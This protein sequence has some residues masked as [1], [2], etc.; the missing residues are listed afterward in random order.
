MPPKK[1]SEVDYKIACHHTLS[2]D[3]TVLNNDEPAPPEFIAWHEAKTSL[4]A[5][6]GAATWKLSEVNLFFLSGG[7]IAP[8]K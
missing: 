5:P 3:G 8:A 2:A 4:R 7:A 1:A 6:P